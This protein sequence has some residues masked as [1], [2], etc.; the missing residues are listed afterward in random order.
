MITAPWNIIIL[1]IS[2]NFFSQYANVKCI[3]LSLFLL[4]GYLYFLYDIKD[5]CFPYVGLGY[6]PENNVVLNGKLSLMSII[7]PIEMKDYF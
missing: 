3:L 2:R 4:L 5:G 1:F 6:L 7:I